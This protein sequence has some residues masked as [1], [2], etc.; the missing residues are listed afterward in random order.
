MRAHMQFPE[1]VDE[2]LD[3]YFRHNPV[4]ATEI[5]HH[6]LDDRWPDLSAAGRDAT[7]AWLADAAAKVDA[8]PADEL[9]DDEEIDRRI[10]TDFLAAARF[11]EETL[12]EASWNPL[13]YVY[14]FGNGLFS[15]LAREFAPADERLRS[16]A[17]RMRTLPE[18]LDQA[19][20]RLR[21]G[22][23]R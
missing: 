22:G 14:L 2:L 4:H 15:L 18:A 19:R 16:A 8:L 3:G 12:D 10:V 20:D 13:S 6:A 21:A 23:H 5:G 1:V 17:S 7:L 11:S 9:T